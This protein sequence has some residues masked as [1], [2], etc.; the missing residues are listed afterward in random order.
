MMPYGQ[1]PVGM[2]G[3]VAARRYPLYNPGYQRWQLEMLRRKRFEEMEWDVNYRQAKWVKHQNRNCYYRHGAT[4]WGDNDRS[5]KV[6]L[7]VRECKLR[8]DESDKCDCVVYARS[9]GKC[10]L[11]ENCQPTMC[12][13]AAWSSLYVR[14]DVGKVMNGI[15]L[16]T[17]MDG[18]VAHSGIFMG[19]F[20]GTFTQPSQIA[21]YTTKRG[22][23]R[24]ED[25]DN[26]DDSN[27]GRSTD[28]D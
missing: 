26:D 28:N 5:A 3:A 2:G 1:P 11:R 20:I 7:T 17:M 24:E 25:D 6:G 15:F 4:T 14:L 18:N 16:G 10:W 12:K 19:E 9:K 21:A 13:K 8:C 22:K 23:G 27:G